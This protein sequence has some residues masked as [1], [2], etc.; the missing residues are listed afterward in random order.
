VVGRGSFAY[1]R[2]DQ[3]VPAEPSFAAFER[4]QAL[5]LRAL[6]RRQGEGASFAE[7]QDAGVEHP[8]SVVSELELAGVPIQ[9]CELHEHGARRLGVRLDPTWPGP[10]A[11]QPARLLPQRTVEEG[12]A[13]HD[14][15]ANTL[16]RYRHV[17]RPVAI[18]VAAVGRVL[19]GIF[20]NLRDHLR[21]LRLRDIRIPDRLRDLH[22]RDRLRVV[23][24]PDHLHDVRLPGLHLRDRLRAVRI[25]DHLHDVQ[26]PGLQLRDRLRDLHLRDH[27]R[28]R[29]R[30]LHLRDRFRGLRIPDHL[31]DLRAGTA[32][33]R[34]MPSH[35]RNRRLLAPAALL[36]VVGV[37]VVLAVG[38][39][40]TG[41]R[42][43]PSAHARPRPHVYT[44]G[45]TH[46]RT[47]QHTPPPVHMP[48][49]PTLAAELQL[50][51]HELLRAGQYEQA[52]RLLNQ[53]LMA[54]G[55]NLQRCLEPV[56]EACLTYAYALY[57]LGRALMLSGSPAAAVPVLE[58]RLQIENQRST[59]AVALE[60]A[61]AQT[62]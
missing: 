2:A 3:G 33:A 43:T 40:D 10:P 14:R 28:D 9:R 55:E 23:R 53:A 18:W 30:D 41:I 4:Q 25:P 38:Q 59:V 62:G 56:S 36:V 42:R 1:R 32:L 57:D 61:R 47:A 58:R 35:L 13:S 6:H 26:L 24:I 11:P 19:I 27:L 5:L 37:I 60:Q 49:S 46:T 31:R 54:S 15:F 21:E 20:I 51:G 52:A 16:A 50:K 29:L 48:V 12:G 45:A 44:V 8:A 22:L 7:L 34:S 17:K 39:L